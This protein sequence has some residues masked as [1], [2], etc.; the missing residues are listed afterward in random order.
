ME[1]KL[2]AANFDPVVGHDPD[3]DL[4]RWASAN[5]ETL[6]EMV[7]A[8]GARIVSERDLLMIRR[9]LRIGVDH[10]A[11]HGKL[12]PMDILLDAIRRIER[13]EGGPAL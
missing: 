7:R 5:R 1:A 9:A 11:R 10:C 2:T 6:D 12:V 4:T 13:A 3:G 8:S